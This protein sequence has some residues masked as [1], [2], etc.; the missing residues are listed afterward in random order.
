VIDN[1]QVAMLAAEH[2]QTI[3]QMWFALYWLKHPARVSDYYVQCRSL[4]NYGKRR[5]AR[6]MVSQARRGFPAVLKMKWFCGT[7]K[8]PC[9]DSWEMSE[10]LLRHLRGE[11]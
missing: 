10:H 4:N 3:D 9:E 5:L 11:P 7:C 8:Q 1:D 2:G 6:E